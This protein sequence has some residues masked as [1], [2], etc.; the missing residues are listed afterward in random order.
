MTDLPTELFG[1]IG[2]KEEADGCVHLANIC[3]TTSEALIK[4]L[5]KSERAR[6]EGL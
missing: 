5:D 4:Q 2:G 3:V 6:V 1:A